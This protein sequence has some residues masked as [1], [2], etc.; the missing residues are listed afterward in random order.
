MAVNIPGLSLSLL[1]QQT[2]VQAGLP[3]LISGRFT[4]FGMGVPTFIRVFLEGPSYDPQLRSFD[5]FASPF[6]GDYSVN[7]IAEK[8]G[9][10][11]VYAQAF[12]PP[13]I[14]TGP[15][16]P[17]AIMLLPP[18]AE[19]TRPPLVVGYPFNGGVD[20]LLPD[21]T[22][23]RLTA[24][25]MQ[26]IEF[27]PMITVAPGISIAAP[28]VPAAYPRIPTY[29]PAVP[30]A[31]PPAVPPVEV[32]TRAAVDDIRFSPEEIN[33]GMEA[34]GVM[35]WRNIGDV[36]HIFDTVFYLVSPIGV[37]YGPLQV[38]QDI[39]A[40]PQVPATQN[41]R[42]STEG[43]PPG[44]YSVVAEIYD[45]TTGAL[46]AAQTLP[47]RLQIREIA[48]PVVPVPPPPVVPEV[49][50]ID[51]LG[52]PSLNLPRQLNVGDVWSGSVSL[53][54]FG[55]VP[56]F[57]E[58]RLLLQDPSMLEYVVAQGGRTLYPGE[59]LQIPVNYN[60]SGFSGGNYTI[61]MRVFDQFGQPIAEFPMGFLTMIEAIAPPEIPVVPEIPT[62][63]TLPTADMFA[64]PSVN[65]P[66]EV[67]IGEIW[68]GNISI[69]TQVPF[70]LQALPSLPAYPVNAGLQLQS[71]I[72]QLFDVGTFRPTFTP[73]QP[74]NLPVNFDT[75]VLPQEGIHN[76]ILNISDLQGNPLFSNIIGSLRA[77]MPALPPG[78]PTPPVPEVPLPSEFI[79][80]IV[81]MGVQRVEVGQSITIPFTYT[82]VGAPEVVTLRAAIGDDR[83]AYLGGFDEVWYTDKTV[84]VPAHAVPTPIRDSITI[85]IT[86]KFQAAG[87]YSVYAKVDGGIP[88]AISPVLPNIIEVIEVPEAPV[89]PRADI[90]DFNINLVTVGPFDPG[91]SGYLIATGRYRGRAQGGSLTISLGTGIVGTFF[92][93]FTLPSI[94]VNFS[95][96]YDWQDFSFRA[97]FTIPPDVELGQTYNLRGR[98]ETFFDPTA[99]D[100]TDWGVI[101]ITAPPTIPSSQ[102]S[103]VEIDPALGFPVVHHGETLQ[104]PINYTHLGQRDTA[105]VY[106][107]IGE[108]GTV[109]GFDE[110]AHGE[111]SIT[112][113]DDSVLRTRQATVN[114]TIPTLKAGRYDLYAKVD[115]EQSSPVLG[116][117]H[118]V[119]LVPLPPSE[120]SG[121]SIIRWSSSTPRGGTLELAV[122]FNHVGEGESE[123]LYAAIGNVGV[124]GFDE[125]VSNRR[126]ITVPGDPEIT[127]YRETITI[128]I[129]TTLSP[130][131]YDVYAKIGRAIS[132]TRENVIRI[133]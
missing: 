97:T 88:R 8:D 89:L 108:W 107:A 31:P 65:L 103:Q 54:T 127:A 81:E 123:W 49:P 98:I 17:E 85:P 26:P 34:T 93:K 125:K 12:P 119:E 36:P 55:T 86:P 16:F 44:I 71:P 33:P 18:F 90:A 52:T 72:G 67:E 9:Q 27:R 58:A 20:A 14:P 115:G 22:R 101:E 117:V 39:S 35:S 38:N 74:I 133:T 46:L 102:F 70:A 75:S 87:I 10:Y 114:I 77:L 120:F 51:I 21:G 64:T 43:L 41:L 59:T 91:S 42:L 83:P 96:A 6:S 28:G 50:T 132:P 122:S 56:Y 128:P 45:S 112:V 29:P 24:P 19:S 62:A 2:S 61:L 63:P 80:I 78:I 99:E 82:H 1:R 109:F 7:V 25:P 15:P 105:R 48:A 32:I 79:G 53:P 40:N 106:A 118:V 4:A 84:S 13:L 30:P 110:M 124:F 69:P 60:T 47:S 94:P 116:R 73:G 11:T 57:A 95:E 5:T 126:A 68:S 37:R 111:T 130:G 121:V 23:Q 66:T 113:P 92:T 100:E 104:V 129:P 131:T 3:L 76:L